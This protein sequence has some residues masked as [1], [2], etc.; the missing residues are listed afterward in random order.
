MHPPFTVIVDGVPIQCETAEQALE[1]VQLARQAGTNGGDAT[2]NSGRAHRQSSERGSISRWTERRIKEFLGAISNQQRKLLDELLKSPDG[3]TDHQLRLA[4]GLASNNALG[5]VFT[6]LS[7]NAKKVG[8][9]SND[10]F[11]S[12]QVMI[13]DEAHRE[14]R[15][16]DSFRKAASG[17]VALS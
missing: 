3:R 14:Y 12:E 9:D 5:G 7:R 16:T 8:A 17:S 11:D 10:L 6:G 2:T 15:L 13:G 4:L 1:L